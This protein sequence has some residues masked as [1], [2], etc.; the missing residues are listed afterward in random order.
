MSRA[1]LCLAA[2]SLAIASNASAH[3]RPPRLSSIAID[4]R[5]PDVMVLSATFGLVVTEDGG[6]SF[7][8]TCA[9][10]FGSDPNREDPRVALTGGATLIGTFAGLATTMDRCDYAFAPELDD[11]L[12]ADIVTDRADPSIV[13]ALA[14]S[15]FEPSRVVRS[16]DGGASWR[17]IGDPFPAVL[18]ER[19]ALAPSDASRVYVSGWRPATAGGPRR[20]FLYASSDGGEHLE[21]T[22]IALDEGERIPYVLGVDPEDADR[23]FV[24]I[25]RGE[26]DERPERLLASDDGGRTFATALEVDEVSAFEI[27]ADAVWVGSA[28]GG[29]FRAD[30]SLAF[31]QLSSTSV[32]CLRSAG[33]TLWVCADPTLEGFALGRS[34]DGGATIDPVLRMQDVTQLTACPRCSQ[35]GVQCPSW[36]PDLEADYVRWLSDADAGPPLPSLPRDAGLPPECGGPPVEAPG[37]GC[38]AAP[39]SPAPWA[40]GFLAIVLVRAI[41]ATRRGSRAAAA[42]RPA[43]PGGAR[44]R[45]RGCAVDPRPDRSR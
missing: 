25:S 30:A 35:A 22:E 34:S 26:M 42:C 4:P 11:A 41:S 12:V 27:D 40:L 19:I 8:W 31:T 18:L 36:Q 6:A 1:V 15:G 33:D 16:D 32:T 9:S 14:S 39:A 23:V 38:R 29:L 10:A 20:A 28:A 44:S 2:L 17:T 13:W 5:D 24:R 37:C 21:P 3:T 7:R 43:S 45:P